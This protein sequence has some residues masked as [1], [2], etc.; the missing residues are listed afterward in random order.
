[1]MIELP[2]ELAPALRVQANAHGISVDGYVREVV[3]RDLA[4]TLEA[5]RSGAPFKTGRPTLPETPKAESRT[6]W[7]VM[8]D[9]IEDISAEEFAKL[10]KD[11]ASQHDHYLYGHPKKEQ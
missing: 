11:G 4:P 9:N 8:L 3:E 7:E 6:I 2:E 10:P 5:Q 1:M